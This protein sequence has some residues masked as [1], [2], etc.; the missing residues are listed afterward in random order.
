MVSKRPFSCLGGRLF[1][2]DPGLVI[3]IAFIADYDGMFSHLCIIIGRM[4]GAVLLETKVRQWLV[5]HATKNRD[6]EDR[7]WKTPWVNNPNGGGGFS[8]IQDF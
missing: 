4:S 6:L 2:P 5:G 3:L 1:E 8:L 7:T